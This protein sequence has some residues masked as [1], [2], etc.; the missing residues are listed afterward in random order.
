VSLFM[1]VRVRGD[2]A[3]TGESPC[4][5]RAGGGRNQEKGASLHTGWA[6]SVWCW[7]DRNRKDMVDIPE[8]VRKD[9]ELV[10]VSASRKPW[11]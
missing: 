6:S 2:V 4:V 8:S 9:M 5:Q 3:M 11:S 10:F 1:A 7:P